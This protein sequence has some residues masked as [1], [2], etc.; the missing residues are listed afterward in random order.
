MLYISMCKRE[1][2][3]ASAAALM[4]LPWYMSYPPYVESSPLLAMCFQYM[5][6]DSNNKVMGES[7]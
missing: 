3:K 2:L 5:C 1:S 6:G 4:P 7:P